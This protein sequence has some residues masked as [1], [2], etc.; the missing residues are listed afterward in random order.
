MSTKSEVEALTNKVAGLEALITQLLEQ[1]ARR[2]AHDDF[3]INHAEVAI[4]QQMY[5]VAFVT[6]SSLKA[7][8]QFEGDVDREA[9]RIRDEW[10]TKLTHPSGSQY[11][12]Q[13]MVEN[14]L[15]VPKAQQYEQAYTERKA[16]AG[17]AAQGGPAMQQGQ[18]GQAQPQPPQPQL[19][20]P[21][22]APPNHDVVY[23]FHGNPVGYQP[24]AGWG[25]RIV[26]G[27]GTGMGMLTMGTMAAGQA[28][29]QMGQA[30]GTFQS[31]PGTVQN[32]WQ[33]GQ[34]QGQMPVAQPYGSIGAPQQRACQQGHPPINPTDATCPYGHPLM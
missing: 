3:M 13:F 11:A 2:H 1:T 14:Y 16:N 25:Q 26:G 7:A 8:K 34:Q 21:N 31:L 15:N 12:G 28:A 22:N 27:F 30:A 17:Q 23:D 32:S 5:D 4:P 10:K 24:T 6:L 20:D 9:L 33:T 19:V 29:G 18:W